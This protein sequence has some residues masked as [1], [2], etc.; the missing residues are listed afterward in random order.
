MPV[1]DRNVSQA[2]RTVLDMTAAMTSPEARWATGLN[3]QQEAAVRSDAQRLLIMAGAGTGKTK[4]LVS[5]VARLIDDGVPPERILLLTFT[6][7]A[8]AEMLRRVGALVDHRGVGRV[9]GGTF[10]GIA[11]RLLRRHGDTVG[12]GAAFT[13]VDQ[14]DTEDVFGLLRHEAGVAAQ[15]QRFPKAGTIAS[16][17]SRVVNEQRPLTEVV[18]KHY[19][20]CG[21]HAEAL[22]EL[23]QAYGARKRELGVLDYD[24]LLLYWSA[25]LDGPVGG[26]TRALFDHVL[27]DEYQDTN[28]IQ[29]DILGKLCESSRLAVVGDDAQAIYAFRAASIEHIRN[30][31]DHFAPVTT[32]TLEQNYR[33]TPQILD[34]AN[35]VIAVSNAV[36]PKTLWSERV[37]GLRP[38]LTVCQDE[39]VQ[40][41]AVCDR[42]LELREQGI[43]LIDQAV[44]FRTGH[45]SS[46]L[47]IEL[48]RRR[49]PYVKFGGLKFLE[50]AHVK[51][52]VAMLR[53][54]E[55]PDDTIAWRRVLQ[56]LPG[57]GPATAERLHHS[58]IEAAIATGE[59]PVQVFATTTPMTSAQ[60]R[61]ALTTLQ[62]S[63]RQALSDASAAPA[64]QVEA[65]LPFCEEVFA[66]NYDDAAARIVDVQQLA[67][68]ASG[69]A[70]RT[71]FLADLV[72]DPP[73]STSDLAGPP[74]LD[75]DYLILSTIHSAKGGEW[76]AVYVIHASD[77][78]IPSDMSL[79]DEEGL[80]EERRLFYVALT[81]AK[82]HLMV[83]YP[84]RYYHQRHGFDGAHTYAPRSRFIDPALEAF[85]VT[86][87]AAPAPEDGGA[88]GAQPA[89]DVVEDR[90][91]ALW[92]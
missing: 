49:I 66:A 6:R 75:D 55:N 34:V 26:A 46:G 19:P 82:D 17:Y 57:V 22:I 72:L 36:H 2:V 42:I 90:L 52:L 45:H 59:S 41:E 14:A 51:D 76:R 70:S 39:A 30:F 48:G 24:D 50:A 18:Q 62:A 13:I 83:S 33:S 38:E 89:P 16:I 78:N 56:L 53:M 12:L 5:R 64:Q 67:V 86:P 9:W 43:P 54:L 65:F 87:A 23:F 40:A 88:G 8:A 79:G 91:A 37:V 1:P 81:R 32:I 44:L 31:A 28:G 73:V 71:A 92:R 74:Y 4:T 77:G 35:R 29:A 11:N 25:L 69:S 80:E 60:V 20:W 21:D 84:Q 68:L 58:A 47:E 3:P 61:S 85:D 7:R 10:H 27:V 63:I 15:G